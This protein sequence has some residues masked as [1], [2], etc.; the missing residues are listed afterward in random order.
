MCNESNFTAKDRLKKIEC[1]LLSNKKTN[2][3][4]T[5]KNFYLAL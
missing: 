3:T 4:L 1:Y 5:V 2:S